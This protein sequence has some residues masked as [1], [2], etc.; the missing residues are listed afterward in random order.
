MTIDSNVW[1]DGQ[2]MADEYREVQSAEEIDLTQEALTPI[3][4]TLN[5]D[6]TD[7]LNS[8]PQYRVAKMKADKRDD[9]VV[10]FKFG[11]WD[12]KDTAFTADNGRMSRELVMLKDTSEGRVVRTY[13]IEGLIDKE[14]DPATVQQGINTSITAINIDSIKKRHKISSKKQS[15]VDEFKAVIAEIKTTP[16]RRH[17]SLVSKAA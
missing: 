10:E 14:R 7:A 2:V 16:P 11:D 3:A 13:N 6:L 15:T 8:H 17:L 5:T 12:C 9:Q 4:E 1:D